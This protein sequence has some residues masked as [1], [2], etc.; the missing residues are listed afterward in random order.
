MAA[1][2]EQINQAINELDA[3]INKSKDQLKDFYL[4]NLAFYY[5]ADS[6]GTQEKRYDVLLNTINQHKRLIDNLARFEVAIANPDNDPA[7]FKVVMESD[8]KD[9]KELTKEF[10]QIMKNIKHEVKRLLEETGS[11]SEK[12]K[13]STLTFLADSTGH[14]VDAVNDKFH[15][16]SKLKPL[17]NDINVAKAGP[18]SKFLLKHNEFAALMGFFAIAT[19][20]GLCVGGA[21]SCAVPG[22]LVAGIAMIAVGV[23]LFGLGVALM[24]MGG[25]QLSDD[26]IA[27]RKYHAAELA[28]NLEQ[29]AKTKSAIDGFKKA[30]QTLNEASSIELT[31]H[32]RPSA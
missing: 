17:L 5:R 22:G 9:V 13:A 6:N 32:P 11:M 15:D 28:D 12:E 20:I 29:F 4:E 25:F 24:K 18:V 31:P 30:E 3:A 7:N 2:L 8:N 1:T 26:R 19:C 16:T 23:A 14:L 21:A 27:G 10:H